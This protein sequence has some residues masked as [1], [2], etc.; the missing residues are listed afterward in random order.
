MGSHAVQDGNAVL[1]G[2]LKHRNQRG[3]SV[4]PH[5]KGWRC[6]RPGIPNSV[7]TPVFETATRMAIVHRVA[8]GSCSKPTEAPW[9][10]TLERDSKT[11]S[12]SV[13]RELL[14]QVVQCHIREQ[15]I[16]SLRAVFSATAVIKGRYQVKKQCSKGKEAQFEQL[17]SGQ[18][19][20]T[21]SSKQLGIFKN[22][23]KIFI[24]SI[25]VYY[26]LK[27]LLGC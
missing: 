16:A 27:Q 8:R 21:S 24:L 10:I 2:A 20:I 18:Q 11:Q 3:A 15:V 19:V 26:F 22:E 5:T 12:L 25:Y 13:T 9:N 14:V 7:C 1:P 23:I 6:V 17:I 4:F